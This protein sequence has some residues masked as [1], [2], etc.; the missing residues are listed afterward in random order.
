MNMKAVKEFFLYTFL[1]AMIMLIM[2][3][4]SI[5]HIQSCTVKERM[6]REEWNRNYHHEMKTKRADDE[7][8]LGKLI[9]FEIVYGNTYGK[10][11]NVVSSYRVVAEKG[12]VLAPFYCPQ[13]APTPCDVLYSKSINRIRFIPQ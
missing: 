4:Y 7:V 3:C 6:D 2:F 10:Y 13:F 1:P 12:T 9:S 5:Y 8:N 11:S